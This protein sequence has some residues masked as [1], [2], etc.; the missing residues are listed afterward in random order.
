MV[1]FVLA[2]VGAWREKL[3]IIYDGHEGDAAIRRVAVAASRSPLSPDA[4]IGTIILLNTTPVRTQRLR[5]KDY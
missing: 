5:R 3:H 1:F 4:D 2:P